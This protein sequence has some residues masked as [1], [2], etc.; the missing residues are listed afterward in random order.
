MKIAGPKES[1]AHCSTADGEQ[2]LDL[3]D[4]IDWNTELQICPSSALSFWQEMP[5]NIPL[6]P[7]INL[8]PSSTFI[9]LD[10][11]SP[12]AHPLLTICGVGSPR[13]CPSPAPLASSSASSHRGPATQRLHHGFQFLVS[14]LV[15]CPPNLQ[16]GTALLRLF[17]IPSSLQ[18]YWAP[19]SLQ[20]HLSPLLLQLRHG[21]SDL[22]LCLGCRSQLLRLGSLDLRLCPGSS[23]LRLCL[24]LH[25]HVLRRHQS[26]PLGAAFMAAVWVLSCSS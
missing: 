13:V 26:A 18:L 6:P 5:P 10:P 16:L 4:L 25:H 14:V 11:V 9:L 17:L 19:P 23:A 20:P 2:E 15:N 1:P 22:R 24:G 3:G 12:S 7:F 8:F 21:L